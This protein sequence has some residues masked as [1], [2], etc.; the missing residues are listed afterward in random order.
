[1]CSALYYI[2]MCVLAHVWTMWVCSGLYYMLMCVPTHVWTMCVCLGAR[3][4][5]TKGVGS[6]HPELH[7]VQAVVLKRVPS[8]GKAADEPLRES[9]GSGEQLISILK[10]VLSRESWQSHRR[11]A[12][13]KFVSSIPGPHDV[14]SACPAKSRAPCPTPA[15]PRG[16]THTTHSPAPPRAAHTPGPSPSQQCCYCRKKLIITIIKDY[17]VRHTCRNSQQ[18]CGSI[19]DDCFYYHSWRNNVQP[20]PLG[21]SFSKA[22]SSKLERLLCHVSV[23]RDVRAL[24]F[25]LWNSI[26]KCHP[27]WDWL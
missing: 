26:R 1:M 15:R 9:W 8:L 20:I 23:K 17:Q 21:V 12:A 13:R 2:L 4:T 6:D 5:Q 7:F 19:D 18:P 3:H 11:A 27:K 10:P 25:E 16:R 24:S 22:Q 14:G